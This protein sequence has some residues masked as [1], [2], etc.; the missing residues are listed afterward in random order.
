MPGSSSRLYL[1]SCP[2]DDLPQQFY[3]SYSKTIDFHFLLVQN[4]F[5][6]PNL[7]TKLLN[8]AYLFL[9]FSPIPVLPSLNSF[10]SLHNRPI[11]RET[12]CWSNEQRLYME[13]QQ[14]R[15]WQTN[16]L[17]N[18]LPVV[19][20]QASFIL[21]GEGVWLLVANFWCQNRLFLHL[22]R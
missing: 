18:H 2:L 4:P 19:R 14:P 1:W 12:S 13:S 6:I 16:V 15:R 10:C 21:K 3:F 17:E 11:N 22:S 20:I 8:T 7:L 9:L 5:I